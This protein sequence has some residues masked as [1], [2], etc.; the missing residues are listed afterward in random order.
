MVSF[1]TA[2]GEVP[3]GHPLRAYAIAKI[4]ADRHL[5]ASNLDW[6]ILGP[7][8]LTLEE[9]TGAITVAR[10]A[11]GSASDGGRTS[12]GNV[13]RVITAV[14]AEPASIGRVIPFYDGD[15]PIAQA[16]A[17]VPQ[18]YAWENSLVTWGDDVAR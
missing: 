11:P 17:D 15:I 7:G 10:L 18:E 3:V 13:A 9:P 6:T 8:L 2:Y 4:A 14:L 12:R 1:N 5:Q 16:V